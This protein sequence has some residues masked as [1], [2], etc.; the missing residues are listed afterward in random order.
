MSRAEKTGAEHAAWQAGFDAG[1]ARGYAEALAGVD[2]AARAIVAA[3]A[4]RDLP[5]QAACSRLLAGY[6]FEAGAKTAVLRVFGLAVDGDDA[7]DWA[8]TVERIAGKGARG[9]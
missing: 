6:A 2:R 3:S 9:V 5:I 8:V 4:R 1:H 7:G